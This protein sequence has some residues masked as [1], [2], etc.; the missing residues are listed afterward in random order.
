MI[1]NPHRLPAST[2]A[3]W[4]GLVAVILLFAIPLMV[5]LREPEMRNDEAI[6][7]YAVERILDTGDWLTPRSI[8]SDSPFLE[9]PP[10]KFWIVAA[11]IKSG[12]LPL[13]EAGLRFFDGLFGAIAFVYVF[14]LGRR[15]SGPL[16]GLVAVLVL[17]T[18]DPLL[19][20]HGLR[21]NNM[22]APLFLCYCGGVYHFARWVEAEAL[23]KRSRHAL[24]VAA[25]FVLG[26]MTKF[27]A[28][29]FLPPICVVA[30][31][32]RRDALARVR[33]GY[34]DWLV[35]IV[36]VAALTVPWFV[37]ETRLFGRQFWDIIFG[38]HVYT[39]FTRSLDPSHVHVWH[40]YFS[41]TWKEIARS[42]SMVLVATGAVR[43]TYAAWREELWLA[44][45]VLV[46]G[47]LPLTLMSFG[48]S[49]LL[50][51]AYPFF[52]PI[53]LAA[54]FIFA[55][56]LGSLDGRIEVFLTR[57]MTRLVP[58]RE[59]SWSTESPLAR[60]LLIV[61]AALAF[62]VS[63]WTALS[64]PLRYEVGGAAW[65][66][67]SSVL[68][69]AFFG[70]LLLWL[71][72]YSKNLFRLCALL[73]LAFLLPLSAYAD[74]IEHIATRVDHPL[75][76]TRDCMASVQAAGAASAS[77][78]LSASGNI[79]HHSYY[80]YLW[81]LGPWTIAPEFSPDEVVNRLTP[82]SGSGGQSPVILQH[83]DYDALYQKLATD[84]SELL[85]TLKDDAVCY[86]DNIAILLPGP[87]A[88]CAGRV[89]EAGG[90]PIWPAPRV[91][92]TR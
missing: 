4:L 8:P 88:S 84:H 53:G 60:R 24:A 13:N 1:S 63:I 19:F 39:R 11:G 22:E 81:R 7:S 18:L 82:S 5:R 89:L 49:K 67:N 35:P 9:K 25:F 68:R 83:A 85:K 45:L 72:G 57:Y 54:G 78:V 56:A 2:G 65:F 50:H 47:I 70:I 34:R 77:G 28:A 30:L 69:P 59:G 71:A 32:W 27:V 80:Y 15:L 48:T 62:I 31:V 29:L 75:R 76:A 52:P 66:R 41:A 10:L 16:C 46:W 64:G 91:L 51:Y 38:T 33:A 58:R 20:E 3:S 12:L 86:D 55:S 40:H 74:K 21:S 73:A 61:A 92:T 37:Y 6:Y 23:R 36:L 14:L 17:F 42:G 90:R 26:F 44:R 43:L 87:Y 79:L